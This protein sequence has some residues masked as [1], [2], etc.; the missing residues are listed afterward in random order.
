MKLVTN[1]HNAETEPHERRRKVKGERLHLNR[2]KAISEYNKCMGGVDHFDQMIKYYQFTRR[3]NKW[4]KK[5]VVYLFQMALFNSFA[6]YRK[7]TTERKN[8]FQELHSFICPGP[9]RV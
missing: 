5:F 8:K 7:Y 1:I 6:L 9:Y 3:T 4:T 2:P